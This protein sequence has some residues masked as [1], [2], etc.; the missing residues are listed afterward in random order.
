MQCKTLNIISDGQ[1]IAKRLS[2]GIDK[3]TKRARQLLNEYNT[4]STDISPCFSPLLLTDILSPDNKIWHQYTHGTSSTVPP[5]VKKD[6]TDAYLLKQRCEEELQL[7]TAEMTNALDYWRKCADCMKQSISAMNSK[8]TQYTR[9][10]TSLL[11]QRLW[12]VELAHSKAQSAFTNILSPVPS[13]CPTSTVH[14]DLHD[15]D[16]SESEDDSISD[17]D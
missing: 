8:S 5:G 2:V 13:E 3:E 7:L 9:G 4:V 6:I 16:F 14:H 12:V 17:E 11:Q 1:K 10:A 15:S